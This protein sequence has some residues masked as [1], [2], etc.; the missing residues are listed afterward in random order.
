MKRTSKFMIYPDEPKHFRCHGMRS[1]AEARKPAIWM[2]DCG[3]EQPAKQNT[4]AT[5]GDCAES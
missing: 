3:S 1:D 2:D 4:Q 5:S